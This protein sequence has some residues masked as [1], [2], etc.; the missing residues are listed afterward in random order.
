MARKTNGKMRWA[1]WITASLVAIGL[2][3][4]ELASLWQ[5]KPYASDP[6]LLIFFVLVPLGFLMPKAWPLL[7]DLA[8]NAV[9]RKPN[10]KGPSG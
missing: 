2:I 7:S 8:Y 6:K 3:C 5:E 9:G 10:G 1:Q 4:F